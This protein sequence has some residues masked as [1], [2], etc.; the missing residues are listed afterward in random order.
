[1]LCIEV[2]VIMVLVSVPIVP[3]VVSVLIV[4][5]E[6]VELELVPLLQAASVPIA[7]TINSFFM[8]LCFL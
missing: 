5:E 1:M 7:K 8:C 2:S 4:L 3:V 6:S